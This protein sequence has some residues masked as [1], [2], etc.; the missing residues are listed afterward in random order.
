MDGFSES[1]DREPIPALKHR[2]MHGV[3]TPTYRADPIPAMNCRAMHGI[4]IPTG[5]RYPASAMNRRV[6][7]DVRVQQAIYRH[8]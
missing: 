1:E 2:A 6:L 8:A 5:G 7:E 3:K 4:K